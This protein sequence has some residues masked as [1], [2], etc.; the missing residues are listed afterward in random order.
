[1]SLLRVCMFK[2]DTGEGEH[3]LSL[4]HSYFYG[5]VHLCEPE[6]MPIIMNSVQ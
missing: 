5:E 6:Q 2:C 4:F 1:M 3:L